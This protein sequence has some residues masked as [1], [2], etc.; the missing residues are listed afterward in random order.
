MIKAARAAGASLSRDFADVEHLQVSRKG[1]AD[2]VSNADHRAEEIIY[3]QL[4]KARPGYGFLME[5]SGFVEG[6]D[7]TNRFIICLL[8]TSPSPR[9]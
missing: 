7:K 9:D 8:Y 6:S 4:K 5:E 1:P 2:F 3:E